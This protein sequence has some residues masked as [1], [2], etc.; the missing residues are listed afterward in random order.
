MYSSEKLVDT[1]LEIKNSRWTPLVLLSKGAS[2]K[3]NGL[4]SLVFGKNWR[5]EQSELTKHKIS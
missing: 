2:K 3:S 1:F 5:E 4:F